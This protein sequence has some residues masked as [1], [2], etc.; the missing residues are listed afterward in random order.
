[1][2]QKWGFTN[3]MKNLQSVFFWFFLHKV[4]VAYKLIIDLNGVFRKKSYFE[5]FGQKGPKMGPK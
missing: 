5:I 1:M 3:F 4:I 2:G